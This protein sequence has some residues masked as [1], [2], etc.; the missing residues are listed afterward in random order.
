M[1]DKTNIFLNPYYSQCIPNTISPT[2]SLRTQPPMIG[3]TLSPSTVVPITTK[4]PTG[5]PSSKAPVS[6]APT[7]APTTTNTP[8]GK[9]SSKAPVSNK[10]TAAPITTITPTGK[11]SS[12]VP[13]SDRPTAVPTTTKTPTG[14]PSSKTSN[15]PTTKLTYS[16]ISSTS[17]CAKLYAQCNGLEYDGPKNC[18]AGSQCVYS[19]PYYSQC[20]LTPTEKPTGTTTPTIPCVATYGSCGGNLACCAGSSCVYK[21]SYYFQ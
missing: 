3:A 11:P 13:V 17:G 21:N 20:L 9:P 6:N 19:N 15:K 4:I 14:K 12:K 10:P 8:T 1:K 16:P 7:D 2:G 18:C 5:K